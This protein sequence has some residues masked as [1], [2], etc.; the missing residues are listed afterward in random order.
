MAEI[1]AQLREARMQA[2]IDIAEI[3]AKTKIRAKYLRALEN[4]EWGLL[5]GAVYTANFLRTYAQL[6]NLDPKPIVDQFK[7]DQARRTG[8]GEVHP[9]GSPLGVKDGQGRRAQSGGRS[10]SPALAAVLV[11]IAVLGLFFVLGLRSDKEDGKQSA[12]QNGN[13][14][15]SGSGGTERSVTSG[16]TTT[17][18]SK[19][20]KTAE[21][22]KKKTVRRVRL[23]LKARQPVRVC[24]ENRT[25]RK[26]LIGG[27]VLQPTEFKSKVFRLNRKETFYLSVSSSDLYVKVGDRPVQLLNGPATYRLKGSAPKRIGLAAEATCR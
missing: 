25:T 4:D 9:I 16:G 24:L 21:R 18:G 26:R 14:S 17:S 19:K 1:G 6:L 10:F 15:S 2:G 5:P 27:R 11:V 20:K 23:K 12:G 13:S 3:E 8:R 22:Q 7:Q